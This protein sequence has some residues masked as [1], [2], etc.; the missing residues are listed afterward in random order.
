MASV[1]LRH[2]EVEALDRG[3]GR[4]QSPVHCGDLVSGSISLVHPAHLTEDD[5]RFLVQRVQEVLDYEAKYLKAQETHGLPA[6]KP[7]DCGCGGAGA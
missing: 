6:R 7:G 2:G 3:I 1:D 4:F 5:M